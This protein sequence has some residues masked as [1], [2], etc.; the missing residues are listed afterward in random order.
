MYEN[1]W[2]LQ[3]DHHKAMEYCLKAANQESSNAQSNNST[4]LFQ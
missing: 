4:H 1:G 3:Q 2:G